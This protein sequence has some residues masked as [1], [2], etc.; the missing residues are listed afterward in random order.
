M[1]SDA[2][3]GAVKVSATTETTPLIARDDQSPPPY[4]AFL[5]PIHRVLLCGFLVSLSFGVTQVPL[6]YVFRLMTCEAY[7]D[8]RPGVRSPGPIDRCSLPEIEAGTARA[9]SLLGCSTTFFGVAN[10]FIT[11]RAIKRFGVKS[12]LALQVFWPAARLAVQNVGVVLGGSVGIIIVQCSQIITIIGGPTGYLLALNTYVAN[13]TE[14]KERTG[15][16]GRLQGCNMFGSAIGFLIGGVLA[17]VLG[18]ITPFQV[19]LTLFLASTIY[20]LLVLPWIAP[21]PEEKEAPKGRAG[22][23]RAFGP[24]KSILPAKWMLKDGRVQMEYGAL[25]L[26]AGVFLAVL[27]TGYIPTLLQMYATDIFGFGTK[28]NSY[29]VSSHSF[30]RGVFLVVA[31][32][33]IIAAGRHFM[34]KRTSAKYL[35]N[36]SQNIS[37]SGADTATDQGQF[38]RAMQDEEEQDVMPPAPDDEQVTFDSDLIFVRFS[39][40]TDG[41]LTLGASFVQEGWQMYLIGALLPFGAGTAS[42]AKGVILQMCPASERTDAL[43]AIALVEMIARLSTTF[44]FGL[45]FAAFAS[46]GKTYLVFICNAGVALLGFGILLCSRFPPQGSTRLEAKHTG[47]NGDDDSDSQTRA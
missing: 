25:V 39:L 46:I 47:H 2:R 24:L 6:I 28:R 15:Y 10:L 11:G 36:S 12:A 20:V 29:L 9:V 3:D 41:I 34:E 5:Q 16:L 32:P 38:A 1:S 7:Y 4:K 40:L 42:A 43:S 22:F 33:R 31:F 27:A 8:K 17:D 35:R 18:I 23:T 21:D 26:A 37:H 45:I 44:L 30:L 14:H 19:T 13:V